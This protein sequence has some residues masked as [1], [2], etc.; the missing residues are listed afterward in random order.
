MEVG[1]V[2]IVGNVVE[3]EEEEVAPR[4]YWALEDQGDDLCKID[5]R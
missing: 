3:L 4:K 2:W 1:G 5:Q